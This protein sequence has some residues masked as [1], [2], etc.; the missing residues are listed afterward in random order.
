V[1]ARIVASSAMRPRFPTTIPEVLTSCRVVPSTV[2]S[3]PAV[4]WSWTDRSRVRSSQ[5]SRTAPPCRARRGK[6][7]A[8]RPV[9]PASPWTRPRPLLPR[10]GL[11]VKRCPVHDGQSARIS[12][13][14]RTKSGR[15]RSSGS[16]TRIRPDRSEGAR[17]RSRVTRKAKALS[18]TV[19]TT[20]G[21]AAARSRPRRPAA[22]CAA[23][24]GSH[25][26][27]FAA[28]GNQ[29]KAGP[30]GRAPRDE[31]QGVGPSSPVTTQTSRPNSRDHRRAVRRM[32]PEASAPPLPPSSSPPR[33]GQSRTPLFSHD[34]GEAPDPHAA[35]LT[36]VRLLPEG[37]AS[38][39]RR[40]RT[41][42]RARRTYSMSSSGSPAC[43][44]ASTLNR[45]P[46]AL[47]ACKGN[48]TVCS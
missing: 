17:P 12:S 6:A 13:R 23:G 43:R 21:S 24:V 10:R 11:R 14:Y 16:K 34:R 37:A 3:P 40:A 25:G 4:T 27:S 36:R 38:L 44:R 20:P 9:A 5:G 18:W 41:P 47:E 48:G 1:P 19:R 28:V 35:T 42:G 45:L 30:T 39:A 7:L 2:V 29:S 33:F 46:L 15:R 26:T 8:T 32:A 22:A 31:G